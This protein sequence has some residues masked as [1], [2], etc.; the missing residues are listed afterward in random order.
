[1]TFGTVRTLDRADGSE[2]EGP[3]AEKPFV[4]WVGGKSR[5]LPRIMPF[6]PDPIEN[7]F[8]PFLGGG[9]VFFGLRSEFAE[10]HIWLT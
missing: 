9:A 6:V 1:M 5:L 8:E 4:R 3:R 2:L 10:L 7:Y